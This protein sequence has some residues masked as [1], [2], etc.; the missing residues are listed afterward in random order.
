MKISGEI[1]IG[2]TGII[3]L[4]VIILGINY[5][6]GKN[7]LGS[8]YSLIALFHNVNGLEPSGNVM[9]NGFKIGTVD[10]IDYNTEAAVPFTVYLEID[11]A[12]PIRTN[13][14]AEIYS[15]DLLGSRAIRIIQSEEAGFM[16][17]GDTL[18]S[19]IENDMIA[20]L[21]DR[22]SPV[23]NQAG[24][25]LETLDSA[26]EALTVLLKDPSLRSV[27]NHVD[28]AAG[29]VN[30]Q[31]SESGNLSRSF[32]NLEVLTN[33]ISAKSGSIQNTISNMDSLTEQLKA[34]E[35]DS[36]ILHLGS[37]TDNLAEIMASIND[38]QG[39]IGKLINEDNM[40]QQLSQLIADLDSLVTDLN[41]NPKKYVSFSLFSR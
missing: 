21:L 35:L 22:F 20:S 14:L 6:K 38:G 28:Q 33:S 9:M 39:S 23:L 27:L 19:Q 29:S 10:N 1:K 12:Y 25:L 16:E 41:K 36:L 32:E 31:L 40:Y 4:I 8:N 37:V 18:N 11:K 3:T 26:G 34:A 5:L 13:S 2:I 7:V 30:N 15:A 17:A 24:D